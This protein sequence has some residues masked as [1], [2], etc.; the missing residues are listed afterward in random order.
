MLHGF[1]S[2]Q[3]DK[4]NQHKII[5]CINSMHQL[6]I[7]HNA[8]PDNLYALHLDTGMSRHGISLNEAAYLVEN[9]PAYL[10]NA[11]FYM[12]HFYGIKEDFIHFPEEL[13]EAPLDIIN[14]KNRSNLANIHHPLS[15]FAK[16]VNKMQHFLEILP[17]KPIS[18]SATDS[19]MALYFKN[20][21]EAE[22]API[23]ENI[24]RPGVGIIGGVPTADYLHFLRPA[25]SVFTKISSVTVVPAGENISY[26]IH[27][28]KEK[29]T[30]AVVNIGYGDGY[31]KMLTGTNVCV[32]LKN[33]KFMCKAIAI[34]LNCSVIDVSNMPAEIVD[35]FHSA[36]VEICGENVDIREFAVKDLCYQ[37]YA[38]LG[39]KGKNK[40]TICI[41]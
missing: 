7:W 24:I 31:M 22:E 27:S 6:K 34:N 8:F 33:Q 16:Q 32:H 15:T 39:S 23:L 36:V 10:D 18:F 28:Y 35:S 17:K 13:P 5:P 26:G 40:N 3:E 20:Q 38:G 4:L 12:S 37:A 19:A 30:I 14:Q 29:K 2:G 1:I 11:L 41:D 9:F 25:F 21:Q